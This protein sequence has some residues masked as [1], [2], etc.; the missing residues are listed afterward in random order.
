MKGT[1]EEHVLHLQKRRQ[2][3][4]EDNDMEEKDDEEEEEEED[5]FNQDS[6]LQEIPGGTSATTLPIQPK[7]ETM[8]QIE[9]DSLFNAVL[10]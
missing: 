2:D 6:A 4:F 1:I 5:E 9:I 3:L 10:H 8:S 7:N